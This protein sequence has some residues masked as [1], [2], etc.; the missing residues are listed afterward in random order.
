MLSANQQQ[1]RQV[2][3]FLASEPPVLLD[4][5]PWSHTFGG[6]H[7]VNLVLVNGGS[8]W[9][10]GG[11]PTAELITR[12]IEN[13]ADIQ[14]TAYFNVPAGYAALVPL[15]ERDPAAADLFFARLRI[16]FFADAALPQALWDRIGNPCAAP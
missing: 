5:L 16:A 1:L 10:D 11:R 13:L 7:N 14:P 9:L 2:W 4:W 6:S 8:L 3:P 12:T 15:L